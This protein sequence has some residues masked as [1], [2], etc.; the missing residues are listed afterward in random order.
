MDGWMGGWIDCSVMALGSPRI[1][2]RGSFTFSFPCIAFSHIFLKCHEKKPEYWIR[3][4]ETMRTYGSQHN[5]KAAS[6]TARESW[7]SSWV[8]QGESIPVLGHT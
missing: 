6:L 4:S 2:L 8:G 5:D 1:K 3:I 7:F